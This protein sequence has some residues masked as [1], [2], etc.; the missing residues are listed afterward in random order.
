MHR[1]AKCYPIKQKRIANI[2]TQKYAHG[3][4]RKLAVE[5]FSFR[6]SMARVEEVV[7]HAAANSQH[8]EYRPDINY[9]GDVS[10]VDD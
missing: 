4:H 8:L 1:R 10:R 7:F 3:M 2:G 5:F 6:K 9:Y